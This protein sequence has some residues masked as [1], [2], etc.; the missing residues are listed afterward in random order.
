MFPSLLPTFPCFLPRFSLYRIPLD[1]F[2]CGRQMCSLGL[3]RELFF[4]RGQR[5]KVSFRGRSLDM[6]PA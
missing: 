5:E 3:T 1:R 2:S 4:E 6:N